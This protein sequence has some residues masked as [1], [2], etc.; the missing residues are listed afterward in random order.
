MTACGMS[1]PLELPRGEA[2]TL[3]QRP[4]LV[5]EHSLEQAALR[6]GAERADRGAVA[7][8]REA[9]GVAVGQRARARPEELGGVRGHPAAALD[10]FVVEGASPLGRR[11]VAHPRERPGEVDRGRPRAREHPLGL[12]E[13]VS[14]QRGER[15]PVGGRDPDRRR[16]AHDHGADRLRDLRPRSRS[17]LDDLLRQPALVEEDDR[18]AVLLEPNDCRGSSMRYQIH[19][20]NGRPPEMRTSRDALRGTRQV[21]ISR[22]RVRCPRPTRRGSAPAPP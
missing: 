16:A 21:G 14:A 3:E 12:G 13:V 15:E 11:V 19:G 9:A 1:G 5:D 18:W 22:G 6:R 2:G 7:A 8:G 17:E 4:G 10:L 20:P